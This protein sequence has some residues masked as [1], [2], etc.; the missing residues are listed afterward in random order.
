M[1]GTLSQIADLVRLPDTALGEHR[2]VNAVDI[3][4]GSACAYWIADDRITRHD[5]IVPK[6]YFD[7]R[8]RAGEPPT[9]VSVDELDTM[10]LQAWNEKDRAALEEAFSPDLIHQA[11]FP[12]GRPSTRGAT[13]SG[14]SWG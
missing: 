5:C 13:R 2:Y 11:V 7:N 3:G 1:P 4:G 8:L 6:A 9:D 12:S 14:R 10:S